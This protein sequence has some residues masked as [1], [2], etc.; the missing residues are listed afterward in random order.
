[1]FADLKAQGIQNLII[2][3]RN[4]GGGDSELGDELLKYLLAK[5]FHNMKKRLLNT[6][7]SVKNI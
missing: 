5:P 1:M 3:I 4:N 7:I 6:A 2:D